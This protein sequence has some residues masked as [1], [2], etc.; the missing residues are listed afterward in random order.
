MK[1]TN[2][3]ELKAKTSEMLR[4]V[5]RGNTVLVTTHG[6]P[7]AMLVPVTEDNIEDALLAYSPTLRKKIEEG[8]NDV[9]A[10]RTM[11]LSEYKATRVK[12][13]ARTK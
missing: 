8:L 2:V 7:T 1:F 3:R 12:K 4:T 11:R 13:K 5:E 6:R 10:G 9:R